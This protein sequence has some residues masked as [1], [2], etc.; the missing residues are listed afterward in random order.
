MQTKVTDFYSRSAAV[1]HCVAFSCIPVSKQFA[2]HESLIKEIDGDIER[3]LG[4]CF[5]AGRFYVVFKEFFCIRHVDSNDL[6]FV[7]YYQNADFIRMFISWVL[8]SH[9]KS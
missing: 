6:V 8:Q 4:N 1:G 2:E 7:V 3:F 9:V 5:F